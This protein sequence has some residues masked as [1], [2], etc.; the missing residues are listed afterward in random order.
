MTALAATTAEPAVTY[1]SDAT[2]GAMPGDRCAYV[3][4]KRIAAIGDS[5]SYPQLAVVSWSAGWPNNSLPGAYVHRSQ[6]DD[7]I[8]VAARIQALADGASDY[9][10]R[11][12]APL[13]VGP[14]V[15]GPFY[16]AS[17]DA[18]DYQHPEN[19]DDA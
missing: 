4:G 12:R 7:Y 1:Q 3:D 13:P 19:D 5:L 18:P 15:G 9:M 16:A 14:E 8:R 10:G 2:P 6:L 11:H 17:A